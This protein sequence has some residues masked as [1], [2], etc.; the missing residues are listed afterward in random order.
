[1]HLDSSD[2]DMNHREKGESN[3]SQPQYFHTPIAHVY[4]CC[5]IEIVACMF[6]IPMAAAVVVDDDI[7][8]LYAHN[9]KNTITSSSNTNFSSGHIGTFHP[10]EFNIKRSNGN[11]TYSPRR[12]IKSIFL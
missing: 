7:S 5:H 4:V 9:S 3:Q 1:M 11:G 12:L 2:C 10:K 8:T 6:T